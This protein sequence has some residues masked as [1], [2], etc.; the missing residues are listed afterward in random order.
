MRAER[1]ARESDHAEHEEDAE[2]EQSNRRDEACP[3][4]IDVAPRQLA[5][6][7]RQQRQRPP[8]L[9]FEVQHTMNEIVEEGRKRTA[10]VVV[11]TASVAVGARK[12]CAAIEA[13][14]LVR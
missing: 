8:D 4:P 5:G 14:R 7:P 11:L 10:D 1:I 9:A 3:L 6:L 12:Q 2:Q 13:V